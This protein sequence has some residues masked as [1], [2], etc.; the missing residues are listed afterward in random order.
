MTNFDAEWEHYIDQQVEVF[1]EP[2]D[3][4]EEGD[5][6]YGVREK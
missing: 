4:E 3:F 2:D 6:E 5:L 1:D